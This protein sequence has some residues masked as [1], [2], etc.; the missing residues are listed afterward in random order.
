MKR[1]GEDQRFER[2]VRW[3]N[4]MAAA[5]GPDWEVI[6][7][8]LPGRTTVHDDPVEGGMRNGLAVLQSSLLA[9]GPVDLLILMLGTND[10]K[11]RFSV[12]AYEISRSLG[13]LVEFAQ[14]S[15]KAHRVLVIS[16]APVTE[17]GVL[18]D[19]FQGAMARQTGM[20]GFIE[21]RAAEL[22]VGFFDAARVIEVSAVDGVHFDEA[23]HA[24]LGRAVAQVVRGMA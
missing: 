16:P 6:S 1:L 15:G 18:T 19:T 17:T 2:S 21:A 11:H 7:D 3:P 24:T 20:A 10:L 12:T 9:H 8:G 4:V 23:A 5:L 22:G 14:T 13:R